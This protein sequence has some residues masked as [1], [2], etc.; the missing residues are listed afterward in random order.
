MPFKS[1]KQAKFMQAIAHGMKM[2]GKKGPSMM[3][4]KKMVEDAGD[5]DKKTEKKADADEKMPM[6]KGKMK[7]AMFGKAPLGHASHH[8][9]AGGKKR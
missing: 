9:K 1:A 5:Y 8:P 2:K 3:T 7:G 6:M 4:A